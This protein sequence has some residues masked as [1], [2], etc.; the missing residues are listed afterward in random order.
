MPNEDHPRDQVSGSNRSTP[1]LHS[2]TRFHMSYSLSV[3]R[4]KNCLVFYFPFYTTTMSADTLNFLTTSLVCCGLSCDTVDFA[5]QDDPDDPRRKKAC[6]PR[7]W[8]GIEKMLLLADLANFVFD[9]F[10]V[11]KLRD[12]GHDTWA[13]VLLC[14]TITTF[15][16][17]MVIGRVSWR[18]A[19]SCWKMHRRFISTLPSRREF[20]TTI[21]PSTLAMCTCRCSVDSSLLRPSCS[22]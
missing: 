16:G 21:T 10:F 14:A 9:W 18:S 6:H 7:F 11:Q 2:S 12:E 3:N 17:T 4:I 20:S 15:V 5:Y 22:F 1:G 13:L 19:P 8:W